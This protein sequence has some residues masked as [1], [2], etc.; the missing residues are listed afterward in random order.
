M[1]LS[2]TEHSGRTAGACHAWRIELPLH[3]DITRA[4]HDAR[5]ICSTLVEPSIHA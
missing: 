2:V 3:V 4:V 1:R 5:P